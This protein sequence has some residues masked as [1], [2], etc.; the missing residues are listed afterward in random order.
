MEDSLS[1]AERECR[2]GPGFA[3]F[4]Y[5]AAEKPTERGDRLGSG[6]GPGGPTAV[7]GRD[8]AIFLPSP[9]LSKTW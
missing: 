8:E 6:I 2:P 4:D 1:L 5:S 7:P 3:P 9:L